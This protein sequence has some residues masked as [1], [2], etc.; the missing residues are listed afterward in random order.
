VAVAWA[1]LDANVAVAICRR[2]M[3]TPSQLV[4]RDLN[5]LVPVAD[6]IRDLLV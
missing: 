4:S 1:D 6:A 2:R 5:P 3:V